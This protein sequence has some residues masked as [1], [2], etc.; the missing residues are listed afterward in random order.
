MASTLTTD[1]DS[2]PCQPCPVRA[3]HSGKV[4]TTIWPHDLA[5][6]RLCCKIDY[7][8]GQTFIGDCFLCAVAAIAHRHDAVVCRIVRIT[9]DDM[10]TYRCNHLMLLTH[11][12][13]LIDTWTPLMD[14]IVRCLCPE[15]LPSLLT[16]L[17]NSR[18]S[19][20]RTP[21]VYRSL[22]ELT[23]VLKELLRCQSR[24]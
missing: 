18:A 8:N 5:G 22:A 11:L 21:P 1:F 13:G 7:C 19:S 15:A 24:R 14:D 2:R 16:D 9:E 4:A 17:L 23:L 20:G 3:C 12:Q 6:K 10:C